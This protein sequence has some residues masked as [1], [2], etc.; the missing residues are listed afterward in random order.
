MLGVIRMKKA[1]QAMASIPPE[2]DECAR[3][4]RTREAVQCQC[5]SSIREGRERATNKTMVTVVPGIVR[6]LCT[7]NNQRGWWKQDRVDGR[8]S[9]G[10]RIALISG[11]ILDLLLVSQR[12][13]H[14]SPLSPISGTIESDDHFKICF[15]RRATETSGRVVSDNERQVLRASFP[16]RKTD[17]PAAR[18]SQ[19][20]ARSNAARGPGQ[21]PSPSMR[22]V[23]RRG[24]SGAARTDE[25]DARDPPSRPA[26]IFGE[27]SSPPVVSAERD[28]RGKKMSAETRRRVR[29][30]PIPSAGAVEGASQI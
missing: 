14:N 9:A 7:R 24:W 29:H 10:R 22:L 5:C 2:C 25:C 30:W 26:K 27:R 1:Y 11:Q 6:H 19:A 16:Q 15:G 21:R 8:R 28:R 20:S 18:Q 23:S 12:L 17:K 13:V 3:D 4:S